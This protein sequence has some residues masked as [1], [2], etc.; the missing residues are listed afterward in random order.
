MADIDILVDAELLDRAVSA[1]RAGGYTV[2]PDG[3]P[4]ALGQRA[5]AHHDP[6][7]AHPRHPVTVELHTALTPISDGRLAPDLLDRGRPG[8]SDSVLL[9]DAVDLLISVAAHF[10]ADRR[11]G[12][13]AALQQLADMAWTIAR[14]EKLDWDE[15]I[16]RSTV[17]R[18]RGRVSLALENVRILDLAPVPG[19]VRSALRPTANASV[20]AHRLVAERVLVPAPWQSL[21]TYLPVDGLA[22]RTLLLP[23]RAYMRAR[24]DMP[25]AGVGRLYLKRAHSAAAVLASAARNPVRT[26]AEML[27]DRWLSRHAML[28][29]GRRVADARPLGAEQPVARPRP[30]ASAPA[31]PPRPQGPGR[32]DP[33]PGAAPG[34]IGDRSI[35][36]YRPSSSAAAALIGG[37]AVVVQLQTGRS[38]TLNPLATRIWTLL[39]PGARPAAIVDSLCG[40][41]DVNRERVRR[42]VD[43]LLAALLDAGLVVAE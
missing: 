1:L 36:R 28:D 29:P 35:A 15:L 24:Y 14:T 4:P 37:E 3:K 34:A 33:P 32:G 16:R 30:I 8:P 22:G 12:S 11:R 21:R 7:L 43:R 9:P 27:L 41:H 2:P 5:P 13:A 20:L 26:A 25:D 19:Q 42:D 39:G 18:L 17:Y 38:R 23:G 31:D 40:E 6:P 10:V